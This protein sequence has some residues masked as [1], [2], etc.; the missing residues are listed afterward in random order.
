MDGSTGNSIKLRVIKRTS[1]GLGFLLHNDEVNHA[2]VISGLVPGCDAERSQLVTIGDR[3]SAVNGVNVE[4]LNFQQVLAVLD[5]LPVERPAVILLKGPLNCRIQVVTYYDSN[6]TPRTRRITEPLTLTAAQNGHPIA[7]CPVVEQNG[8]H[9]NGVEVSAEQLA[10]FNRDLQ[11][12]LGKIE[13]MMQGLLN[14]NASAKKEHGKVMDDDVF[15]A[16][17]PSP[18]SS[19]GGDRERQVQQQLHARDRRLSSAILDGGFSGN[20][21]TAARRRSFMT[22]PNGILSSHAIPS[23]TGDLSEERPVK[24]GSMVNSQHTRLGPRSSAALDAEAHH[25]LSPQPSPS[26]IK[27]YIKLK[28]LLDGKTFVDTLHR[29]TAQSVGCTANRCTASLLNLSRPQNSLARSTEE[30]LLLAKDFIR[31]YFESAKRLNTPAHDARWAEVEAQIHATG[32]YEFKEQE[33]TFA[34]KSAWRNSQRCIGRIQWSKLQVFDARFINTPRTMFEALLNHIKYSTNRGNLRSAITIFKQRTTP[35]QDFRIW[36]AQLV[37]Y[38]GYKQ[39]DGSVIGD[40]A[41]VELTEVCHKLGWKGSGGRFDVLPLVLS[42]AGQDPEYFDIPRDI[43]LQVA[44]HHAEYPG[45]AEMGLKWYAL[46]AVANMVFDVGGVFFPAVA[47]S[48]W[49]MQT[50]IARDFVDP[51][52][53][54]L[55]EVSVIF[56][57]FEFLDLEGGLRANDVA[58]R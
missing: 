1:Y 44:I 36:N 30:V 23:K 34:A 51:T 10:K 37:R 54:N 31:Q 16:P 56:Q 12:R 21:R 43:V 48:G 17:R 35:E 39:E 2:C 58:C 40:P 3:L 8:E 22:A 53:Y 52:R 19:F 5:A 15:E 6:G 29:S 47:F 33:L 7:S 24:D 55:L 42:A 46:P 9:R 20:A 28:N 26:H 14:L 25:H 49:Y 57:S 41:S 13:E 32:N 38:A 50:E 11:E 45:L 18:P 27:K 4:T